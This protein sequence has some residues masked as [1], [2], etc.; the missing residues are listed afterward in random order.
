MRFSY[1]NIKKTLV[2]FTALV[3]FGTTGTPLNHSR[4]S[5]LMNSTNEIWKDIPN[6]EGMY[7]ISNHGK[8]KSMNFNH[9]KGNERVLKPYPNTGGYLMVDLG[10]KRAQKVHRL[11][12]ATFIGDITDL[13]INHKDFNRKNNHVSNLEIIT[14]AENNTH[15]FLDKN[16]KGL[17]SS[18]TIG[19]YQRKKIG[20]AHV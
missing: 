13:V 12:A 18:K 2:C 1:K 16:K 8:V 9:Q 19:V 11:V 15:S 10:R 4:A 5:L 14:L 20:R 7:M 17:Y 6:Y 3:P